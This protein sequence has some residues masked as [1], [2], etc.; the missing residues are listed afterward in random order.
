MCIAG[1]QS[2]GAGK[3]LATAGKQSSTAD[4]RHSTADKSDNPRIFRRIK[5]KKTE[6]EA[7]PWRYALYKTQCPHFIHKSALKT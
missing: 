3:D 4:K 5:N 1:K 6:I 7:F 2:F